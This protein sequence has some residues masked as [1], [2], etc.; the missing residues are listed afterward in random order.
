MRVPLLVHFT[1]Q[2]ETHIGL[3]RWYRDVG[4]LVIEGR[5]MQ[6]RVAG[7]ILSAQLGSR[8]HQLG[9]PLEISLPNRLEE[10][11]MSMKCLLVP[12]RR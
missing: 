7:F 10:W 9:E 8:D 6:G 5:H 1:R 11:L 2:A 4:S 12:R 3:G